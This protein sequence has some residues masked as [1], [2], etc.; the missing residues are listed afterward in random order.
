[1][2]IGDE[3][4]LRWSDFADLST[5]LLY[6]VLRFRQA[7]FV[8]EQA[9]AYPDLDGVDQRAHHLL[10][11]VDST[12]GGYLRLI[13]HAEEHRVALGRVAVAASLRRRGLARLLMAEGLARCRCDY[14]DCRV[15]LAAQTYL[16][17]FYQ[18]LGFRPISAPFDDH[19]VMHVDM[20]MHR[21][22]D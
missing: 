5:G 12:L 16:I 9:C 22:A 15:T 1:M 10:L 20:E 7:I 14:P 2:Q 6:E 13:P 19:G 3:P 8:V 17:D 21:P 18:S 11:H 4:E